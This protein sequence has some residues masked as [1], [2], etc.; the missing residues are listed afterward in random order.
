MKN[1]ILVLIISMV[2][3]SCEKSIIQKQD[4]QGNWKLEILEEPKID[5]ENFVDIGNFF[6]PRMGMAFNGDSLDFFNG[7]YELDSNKKLKYVG[8]FTKYEIK[9]NKLY[10]DKAFYK[11]EKMVWNVIKVANDTIFFE[12]DDGKFY[13]KRFHFDSAKKDDFDKIIYSSTGCYGTCPIYN[14]SIDSEGNVL[15]YG[16]EYTNPIGIYHSK[17]TTNQT[18]FI[19][20]KF[21]NANP[22]K[23]EDKYYETVTDMATYTTTFVKDGKV[24]KTIYDY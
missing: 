24:I 20:G 16:E 22:I 23:L 6:N 13:L 19:F 3:F 14:I 18:E 15:F 11:N 1:L 7:F 2:A 12:S 8:N 4:L 5:D 9:N 17:A 10:I 21:R